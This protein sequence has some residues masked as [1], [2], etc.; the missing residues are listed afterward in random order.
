MAIYGERLSQNRQTAMSDSAPGITQ[1]QAP[2]EY[3]GIYTSPPHDDDHSMDRFTLQAAARE[4][5]NHPGLAAC[6]R[7]PVPDAQTVDIFRKQKTGHVYYANLCTCKMVWLC[8]VC[9]ARISANRTA[10]ILGLVTQID[11][12]GFANETG[13]PVIHRGLKYHVAMMTYTIGHKLADPLPRS[14]AKLKTAYHRLWSGKRAQQFMAAYDI[15]G[16]LRAFEVTH[17]DNGWHPH[18]HTLLVSRQPLDFQTCQ[19]IWSHVGRRWSEEIESTG[20]YVTLDRGLDVTSGRESLAH[21]ISNAG[22]KIMRV[23]LDPAIVYEETKTP[24]KLGHRAGRT[25]WELL[26]WYV[27]GDVESGRLWQQAQT[28]L[29][30]T[31][32]LLASP[33]IVAELKDAEVLNDS[34]TGVEQT[35]SGD[36]LLAQLTL[37]EW[38]LVNR[39]ALRGLLLEIAKHGIEKDIRVFL[40]DLEW[41]DAAA[42]EPQWKRLRIK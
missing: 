31:R 14:M 28:V 12:T 19:Q 22:N 17:G 6:L 32:Q 29:K 10:V 5:S 41:R 26:A 38:R 24:A 33:G 25:L 15:V 23:K 8:P 2:R 13:E 4:L 34:F 27:R 21:Y 35:D 7:V 16:T 18:I 1:T 37:D 3:I 9:A 11:E 42:G 40:S 39:W 36:V 20:G 30:G